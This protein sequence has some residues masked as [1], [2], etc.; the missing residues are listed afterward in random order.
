[1]RRRTGYVDIC[2]VCKNQNTNGPQ[3]CNFCGWPMGDDWELAEIDLDT[4]VIVRT[5]IPAQ[6]REAADG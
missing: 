2:P 3:E 4:R 1:M 6:T 5:L